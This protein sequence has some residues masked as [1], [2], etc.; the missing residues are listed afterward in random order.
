MLKFKRFQLE[1]L[2]RAALHDGLIL[3]DEPGLGK[4]L[5]ALA[6]ALI[7]RPRRVLIVAPGGLHLQWKAEAREKFRLHVSDLPDLHTFFALGLDRAPKSL[8]K[9]GDERPRFFITTYQDLGFNGADEWP[10]TISDEGFRVQRNQARRLDSDFV[11][12]QRAIA[13]LKGETFDPS[14]YFQGIGEERNGIRCVWTPTLARTIATSEICGGGFDMVII[15]E[16]TKIQGNEAHIANGV[17]QLNPR[18]RLVLTGTP[19]KN[20]LESFFWLAW[21]A[22]G[23]SATPTA[24]WPYE[25]TP[26]AREQF[27]NQHLQHDRFLTREEE[28]AGTVG[29]VTSEVYDALRSA[30]IRKDELVIPRQLDRRL[31]ARVKDVIEANGG[32]WDRSRKAH[33]FASNPNPLAGIHSPVTFLASLHPI[34]PGTGKRRRIEKRSARICNIHRLWK[35][36]APIVIRRRKADCGEDIV[37]K[38]LKPIFVPPGTAQQA[39]YQFHLDYPPIMAK[40]GKANGKLDPRCRIGMQLANLRQAALCP[41]VRAL[42]DVITDPHAPA[43]PKTSWTDANPKQAAILSLIADLLAAGEQVVIGSPFRHFSESLHR[44]LQAAG[45]SSLLLDGNTAQHRRGELVETFKRRQHSV[46]IA[47]LASMAEGYNLDCCSHLIIPSLSWAYDENEQFPHRVWRLTSKK[48][49]T[50]YPIVMR[51]TIDERLLSLYEE[52]SGSAQLA[53]DG[54]LTEDT[55]EHLD[56][57]DLLAHAVRHFDPA[58][59]T[60]DE[61]DI[62]AQW[63]SNLRDNLTYSEAAFGRCRTTDG[64]S[65]SITALP[66]APELPALLRFRRRLAKVNASAR[67]A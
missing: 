49:V 65:S 16:G 39:A 45:V 61:R 17:R 23:G 10:D 30:V 53:L 4:T 46:L 33:V 51:N 58:A 60:V 38:T 5:Q 32:R 31:Y 20:R 36:I 19:I 8:R 35:L 40:Q 44:R 37:P 59:A 11:R 67:A 42:A 25:G 50:I 66:P 26:E 22:C 64:S 56:L 57:A 29:N 48:P 13:A 6:L 28:S 47:G 27:A 15:D 41:D 43:G 14:P 2:A 21:W 18:F 63:A 12:I 9:D 54:E 1:D 3:A 62:E 52:K 55:V 7:K 24:R 34:V